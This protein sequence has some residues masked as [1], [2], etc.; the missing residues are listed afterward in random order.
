[1]NPEELAQCQAL[2]G[3]PPHVSL[4][5]LER[6]F[7]KKNFSLIKGRSGSATDVNPALETERARLKDALSR[8][9]G[10]LR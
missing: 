1:M 3:V 4:A 6:A 9:P 2:L 5:E 8:H 7:M 10:G